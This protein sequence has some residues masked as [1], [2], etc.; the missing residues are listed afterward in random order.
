MFWLWTILV[1]RSSRNSMLL[2]IICVRTNRTLKSVFENVVKTIVPPIRS[3]IVNSPKME[4]HWRRECRSLNVNINSTWL[5]KIWIELLYTK[6]VVVS[7]MELRLVFSLFD[8]SSN[9]IE[10]F[11]YFHLDIYVDPLP[12]ACNGKQLIILETYTTNPVGSPEPKLPDF[13]TINGEI[14]TDSN[15]SMYQLSRTKSRDCRNQST[16]PL[17]DSNKTNQLN[18]TTNST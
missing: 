17:S 2:T 5:W 6:S 11:Q 18:G 15:F 4:V 9:P 3:Q 10:Y 13:L 14:T 7:I 1:S 16:T 8:C 12:P